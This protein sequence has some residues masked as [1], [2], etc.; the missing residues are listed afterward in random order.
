MKRRYS[1]SMERAALKERVIRM[2]YIG[3]PLLSF[4]VF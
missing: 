3:L 4:R 2:E 1:P